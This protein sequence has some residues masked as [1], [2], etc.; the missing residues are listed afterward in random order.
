M[1]RHFPRFFILLLV[2]LMI[3]DTAE[4][5]NTFEEKGQNRQPAKAADWQPSFKNLKKI[6]NAKQANKTTAQHPRYKSLTILPSA[7]QKTL[8]KLQVQDPELKAAFSKKNGTPFFLK[9]SKVLHQKPLQKASQAAKSTAAY[10]FLNLN[11]SLIQID[12]PHEEFAVR[13]IETDDFGTFIR[14]DQRY[15]AFPVWISDIVIHLNDEGVKTFNGRYHKTPEM[16]TVIPDLAGDQA[17]GIVEAHMSLTTP[18]HEFTEME[19]KLL[20]HNERTA[21]LVIFPNESGTEFNWYGMSP[22]SPIL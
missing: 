7:A 12:S 17:I 6:N 18:L 1:N 9:G 15:Q 21:E 20:Q 5:Q 19:S 2:L 16:E 11:K 22:F 13:T 10:E 14:M 8:K 4:A 3:A